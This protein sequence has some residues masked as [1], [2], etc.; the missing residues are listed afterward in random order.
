MSSG[1]PDDVTSDK[2]LWAELDVL[3]S[4]HMFTLAS[5]VL[6]ASVKKKALIQ[7]K[8]LGAF[9]FFFS[10]HILLMKPFS[11]ENN[12]ALYVTSGFIKTHHPYG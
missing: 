5:Q 11:K 6:G 10:L 4:P 8:H 2:M 9:L 3:M 7:F 1:A 12:G